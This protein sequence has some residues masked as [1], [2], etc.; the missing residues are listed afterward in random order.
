MRCFFRRTIGVAGLPALVAASVSLFAGGAWA[1]DSYYG[2]R[3]GAQ[4]IAEIFGCRGYCHSSAGAAGGPL[5][6]SF[7]AIAEKYKGKDG[8]PL[9]LL[10]NVMQGSKNVWGNH[11]MLPQSYA[12]ESDVKIII[13]WILSK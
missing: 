12:L 11:E 3:Y 9:L 6:P 5:G 10:N 13:D 7:E 2:D 8:A 4:D 1:G